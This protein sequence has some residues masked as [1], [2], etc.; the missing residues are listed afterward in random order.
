ML[1]TELKSKAGF[2]VVTVKNSQTILTIEIRITILP[3]I[4]CMID[5]VCKSMTATSHYMYTMTENP[6]LNQLKS[7]LRRQY[8]NL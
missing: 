2:P 8:K 6:P 3:A 7:L 5:T 1:N 4:T